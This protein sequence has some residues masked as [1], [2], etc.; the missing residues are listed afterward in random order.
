MREIMNYILDNMRG[1]EKYKIE[2]YVVGL[3]DD[4]TL[5]EEQFNDLYDWVEDIY[6]PILSWR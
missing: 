5:T 4:G 2:D 3:Y 1:K 6:K